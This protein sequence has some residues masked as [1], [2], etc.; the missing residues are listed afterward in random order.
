MSKDPSQPP[1]Q[2]GSILNHY[3]DDGDGDDDVA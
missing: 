1:D 3:D 2:K